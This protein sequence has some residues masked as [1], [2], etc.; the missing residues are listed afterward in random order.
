M[1]FLCNFTSNH[2]QLDQSVTSDYSLKTALSACTNLMHHNCL[3]RTKTVLFAIIPP[4]LKL[5]RVSTS[6]G[7]VIRLFQAKTNQ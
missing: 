4:F 2:Q 7:L 6:F 5:S 3:C 1:I